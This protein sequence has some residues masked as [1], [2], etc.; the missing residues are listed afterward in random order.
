MKPNQIMKGSL[1]IYLFQ[2]FS[3]IIIVVI[4]LMSSYI[5]G[6]QIFKKNWINSKLSSETLASTISSISSS[7]FSVSLK[8][9]VGRQCDIKISEGKIKT[10]I[11]NE[12]YEA[13]IIF[14]NYVKMKDSSTDCGTGFITIK[15]VNDEV[16][17]E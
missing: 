9:F 8:I 5:I 11:S 14:P 3:G 17:I 6:F 7:S 12:T 4:V 16:W 2:F 15:K 13:P 1:Q 10:T